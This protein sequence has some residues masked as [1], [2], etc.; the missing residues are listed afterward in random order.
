MNATIQVIS[1]SLVPVCCFVCPYHLNRV[2]LDKS[3]A[4]LRNTYAFPQL[5]TVQLHLLFVAR[6][7]SFRL[8]K[9]L[10]VKGEIL[11]L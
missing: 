1:V 2:S 5:P 6:C 9:N 7:C 11:L 4:K 10:Y 8:L 3:S